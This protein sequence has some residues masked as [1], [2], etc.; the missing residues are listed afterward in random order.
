MKQG[1]AEVPALIEEDVA[2]QQ[3]GRSTAAAYAAPGELRPLAGE[4]GIDVDS[5]WK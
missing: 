2:T 5:G 3:C 4:S 1:P